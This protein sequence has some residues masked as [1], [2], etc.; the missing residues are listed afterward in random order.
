MRT[1]SLASL[2]TLLALA[3]AACGGG[4]A[5]SGASPSASS[6]AARPA[7]SSS[8]AS[9]PASAAA[10]V[11]ASGAAAGAAKGPIKVGLMEPLSGPQSPNGK[12]G[13]DGFYL[14][15]DSIGRKVAGRTIDV[16]EADTQG[17]ADVALS[18]AKQLVEGNGAQVLVGFVVTP[19]CYA[20]SGYVKQAHVPMMVTT[21]CAGQDLTTNPKY[22]SPYLSRYSNISLTEGDIAADWAYGAGYRKAILMTEDYA[23]G[24]QVSDLFASAFISRGG[25]IVQELHPPVGTND[26]GAYLAQLKPEAD[27]L[28][29]FEVGVDP[30]RFGAQYPNYVGQRKLQVLDLAGVLSGADLSKLQDKT[31][32]VVANSNYNIANDSPAN[33]KFLKAW[34]AKYPGRDASE[35]VAGGYVGAQALVAAIQA[36][37]GNIEDQTKFLD[38]IHGIKIDT[39]KGT[40]RLDEHHDVVQS[41]FI[42]RIVK[43]GNGVGLKLLKAYPAVTQFWDRTPE[44]LAAFKAGTHKGKWVGM[45]KDKLG[46]VLTTPSS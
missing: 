17:Q 25:S 37:N 10:S 13:R 20:V 23:P 45:T 21:D 35:E 12:D 6:P 29:I 22:A 34:R 7:A 27:L 16:M 28:T 3:L 38:A 5:P 24:L 39:P 18:K 41:K 33:Q 43:E 32:G 14:Y 40:I 26:F 2:S 4:A 8:P 36:V 19:E 31:V 15:V 9:A 46:Q 1:T 44:Q 30:L 11:S 42:V